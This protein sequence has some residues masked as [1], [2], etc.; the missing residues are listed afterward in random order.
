MII[1]QHVDGVIFTLRFNFVR[2]RGAQFCVRRLLETN[3]PCFGAI[4]NGLDLSLS[5]YYYGEYYDKS[6]KSYVAQVN[7]PTVPQT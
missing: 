4:L 6:Y 2:T 1:V 3:V 5:D 7:V